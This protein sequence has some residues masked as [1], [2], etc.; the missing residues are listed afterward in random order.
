MTWERLA[1]QRQSAHGVGGGG[2]G[3]G[4]APFAVVPRC[5]TAS[6]EAVCAAVSGVEI[7]LTPLTALAG[8]MN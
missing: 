4:N 1:R 7:V 6:S 2:G 5:D 8:A 3:G